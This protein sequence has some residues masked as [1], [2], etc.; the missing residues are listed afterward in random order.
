MAQQQEVK[1]KEEIEKEKLPSKREETINEALAVL[2]K[3]DVIIPAAGG[4]VIMIANMLA[5]VFGYSFGF[6]G[7]VLLFLV[8]AYR[9]YVRQEEAKEEKKNV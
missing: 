6:D 5:A 7:S 9:G 4:I 1:L 3:A 8:A 2:L